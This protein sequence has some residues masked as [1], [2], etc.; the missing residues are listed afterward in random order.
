MGRG[1][2][3]GCWGVV[4]IRSEM[5]KSLHDVC[6]HRYWPSLMRLHAVHRWRYL[7]SKC[8]T[9][10]NVT[11]LGPV[12][13]VRP[14]RCQ[15]SQNVQMFSSITCGHLVR[16]ATNRTTDVA[17]AG[18]NSFRPLHE[19]CLSPGRCSLATQLLVKT[20]YTKFQANRPEVLSLL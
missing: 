17:C 14:S 1:L 8:H 15:L 6:I 5:F 2:L 13:K 11:S 10:S 9:V 4:G 12:S 19:V 3:G 20:Y 18:R 7:L 16:T